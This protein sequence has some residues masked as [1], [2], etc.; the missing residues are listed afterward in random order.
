M[1][2]TFKYYNI[3]VLPVKVGETEIGA[4]GYRLLFE[5]Y[6]EVVDKAQ[7]EQKM[8]LKATP[9]MND[10]MFSGSQILIREKF[11]HGQFIRFHHSDALES[12]Y[13]IGK[14]QPISAEFSARIY[15]YNYVFDYENHVLAIHDKRLPAMNP[16][17]RALETELG[18]IVSEFFPGHVLS[19]NELTSNESLEEL[20][21]A[22]A[23]TRVTVNV[24][25]ANSQGF[26]EP[27]EQSLKDSNV[28]DSTLVEKAAKGTVMTSITSHMLSFLKLA[29]R[30]GDANGTM[31]SNGKVRKYQMKNKPVRVPVKKYKDD[32][33]ESF[34][35][36]QF[37]SIKNALSLTRSEDELE[38]NDRQDEN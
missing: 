13:D 31:I 8:H 29:R 35:I 25:F 26:E 6:K 32:D 1:Q 38:A 16:L 21:N 19:I 4:K 24:S 15:L 10:Y 11:T 33:D 30:H 18:P 9:L 28:A 37:L 17:I 3:E 20:L 2:L 5:K 36:N 14:K 12:L 27:L 23:Y 7:N 22:D 34:L